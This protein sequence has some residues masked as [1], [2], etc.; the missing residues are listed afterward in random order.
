M[1]IAHVLLKKIKLILIWGLVIAFLAAII[2]LFLPKQYSAQSKILIIARDRSGVDPYTQSKSAE[3]IGENLALV[4][5]TSDF[6]NKVLNSTNEF[7]K[8]E[9]KNLDERK[10]RKKWAKDIKASV[11]YGTGI[12]NVDAYAKSKTDAVKLSKAIANS[13]AS[14]GWEYVGGNVVLK[15]VSEPLEP[16]FP[17]RPNF[18][19]NIVIGFIVGETLA[20][21]WVM[22]YKK[23]HLLG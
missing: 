16:K 18:V 23:H 6:Y 20:V 12:M 19:L 7:N 14:Y 4:I 21:L 5:N 15:V 8:D 10:K 9:W 13:V 17:T 2:T 3:R 11:V 22:R 1:H